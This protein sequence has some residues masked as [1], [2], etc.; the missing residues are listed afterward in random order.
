MSA[1]K[2]V[3]VRGDL[4]PLLEVRAKR[5][6]TS[7][8]AYVS[9]VL[10][11]HLHPA[12]WARGVMPGLTEL[13]EPL[14]VSVGTPELWIVL[15]GGLPPRLG[16]VAGKVVGA[17]PMHVRIE[18]YGSEQRVIVPRAELTAWWPIEHPERAALEIRQALRESQASSS[19]LTHLLT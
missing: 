15:F 16:M 4:V 1:D 14:I 7:V 5:L 18:V 8:N 12:E 17:G 11:A 10:R 3:R 13:A 9:D 6:D 19:Y 2:N